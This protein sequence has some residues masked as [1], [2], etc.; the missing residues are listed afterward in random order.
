MATR[1]PK[2]L[3]ASSGHKE[4]LSPADACDAIA[5]GLRAG[6]ASQALADLD[7]A[8]MADGGDGLIDAVNSALGGKV[9]TVAA[10]DPLFRTR[11]ARMGMAQWQGKTTALIESAEA[12]G[13]ALLP[14]HERQTMLATSHGLGE[15]ILH[16]VRQGSRRIVIGLGGSIVTDCGLGM[17]QALGFVF[18]DAEGREISG[19]GNPGLSAL[20][21]AQVAAVRADR[22]HCDFSGIEILVASDVDIPLLGPRGQARTFGP[23]KYANAMEIEYLEQGLANVAGVIARSFGRDVDVP[24]AGAAGGIAAGLMGFLGAEV[25]LG[26]ELVSSIIG[27]EARMRASDVVIIGE[28]RLDATTLNNKAPFYTGMLA[29]QLGRPVVAIVG[30]VGSVATLDNPGAAHDGGFFDELFRADAYYAPG[31]TLTP[32]RIRDGLAQAARA[33]GGA[34]RALSG[35]RLKVGMRARTSTRARGH[36]AARR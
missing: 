26:A 31:G 21:L 10:R 4:Y 2:V 28:G 36:G 18:L 34:V 8:P 27:L 23:Q 7:I 12:C 14:L 11:T 33:A 30:S 19:I 25:R 29:H 5:A 32:A 3:V 9:I 13:A 1:Q 20:N 15:L 17:A 6:D 16:A 24:M 22:L 35:T